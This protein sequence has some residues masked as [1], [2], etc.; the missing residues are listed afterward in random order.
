MAP[1]R[2]P[3]RNEQLAS[4]VARDRKENVFVLQGEGSEKR[5]DPRVRLRVSA[6]R[7]L[8]A[9]GSDWARLEIPIRPRVGCL[10]MRGASWLH[11]GSKVTFIPRGHVRVC[12]SQG[13]CSRRPEQGCSSERV[14]HVRSILSLYWEPRRRETHVR[15]NCSV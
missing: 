13:T 6:C 2:N 3:V 8:A 9:R 14:P 12:N 10:S 7:T 1:C 5:V 15:D 11:R 4:K